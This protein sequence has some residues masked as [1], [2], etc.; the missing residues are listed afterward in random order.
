M[1]IT[2]FRVFIFLIVIIAAYQQLWVTIGRDNYIDKFSIYVPKSL[3]ISIHEIFFQNKLQKIEIKKLNEKVK[4]NN[5]L[6]IEFD[7]EILAL[8]FKLS[9]PIQINY[10]EYREFNVF[11]EKFLIKKYTTQYNV[12]KHLG[13][14]SA[15]LTLDEKNIYIVGASGLISYL[16]KKEFLSDEYYP[17]KINPINSNLKQIITDDRF[18]EEST[19]GIKGALIFQ[20]KIYISYTKELQKDCYNTSLIV[21]DLNMNYLNFEDF[22]VK[23]DCVKINNDYGE[24]TAHQSGGKILAYDENHILFSVGEYRYRD[25][26]QDKSNYFGKIIKISLDTKKYEI[27][28]MGHRNVQGMYYDRGKNK[29][30]SVEHGPDGGD[31]ININNLSVSQIK[32]FGWPISSYGDHYS[33]K[34]EDKRNKLKYEKAPFYKSHKKYGFLEPAFYFPYSVAPVTITKIPYFYF[35]NRDL[36][37]KQD[38][39]IIGTLGYQKEKTGI[40][41]I[42]FFKFED[43]KVVEREYFELQERVRDIIYDDEVDVF[44]LWGDS[45]ASIYVL[46][47]L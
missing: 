2:K 13:K 16:K 11:N 8:K 21:A 29:I 17:K 7:R 34:R 36:D 40:K 47:K 14:A 19:F 28:S 27:L 31:E 35:A 4:E 3:K 9:E 24:F 5:K 10:D 41:S 37:E 33:G 12:P 39:M 46:K 43:N 15:Y 26:A 22:L 32:N 6:G 30:F 44:Y 20:K 38:F 1:K 45:S 25:H 23:K 42:H 18:Y